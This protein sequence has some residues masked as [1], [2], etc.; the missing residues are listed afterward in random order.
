MG[1]PK[2]RVERSEKAATDEPPEVPRSLAA[3]MSP[4]LQLISM[5]A[6]TDPSPGVADLRRSLA[7]L[8]R[9][10]AGWQPD[11]RLLADATR[12]ERWTVRRHDDAM[13]CQFVGHVS[14]RS[15]GTSLII[16]T[17]LAIDS[18]AGWALLAGNRW[19]RLGEPLSAGSPPPHDVARHAESWLR[20]EIQNCRSSSTGPR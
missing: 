11:E 19:L 12:A 4:P 13:V 14:Q 18:D 6:R 10:R 7:T 15:G 8:G 2:P 3:G 1:S 9:L 17:V 5:A 16:A 20:H